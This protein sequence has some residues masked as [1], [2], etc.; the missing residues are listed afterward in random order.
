M[1]SYG[2][3]STLVPKILVVAVT[4]ALVYLVLQVGVKKLVLE[5]LVRRNIVTASTLEQMYRPLEAI[6]VAL[7][8]LVVAY[9]VTYDPVV[10]ASLVVLVACLG[11]AL[12][13]LLSNIV[14][15]YIVV[16]GHKLRAGD[17]IEFEGT[18]GRVVR[19]TPFHVV[20]RTRNGYTLVVP[21][22]LLLERS[23]ERAGSGSVRVRLRVSIALPRGVENVVARLNEVEGRIRSTLHARRLIQKGQDVS[24]LIEHIE[25]GKAVLDIIV[26]VPSP[27][28]RLQAVNAIVR[29]VAEAL[30]DY[31]PQIEVTDR[32]LLQ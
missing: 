19:V 3:A 4:V 17:V 23:F 16:L 8:A 10:A 15:F 11:A 32:A 31:N 26:P 14:A 2:L 9:L 30:I 18:R 7:S 6:L 13:P 22:K 20:L 1:V 25:S 24:I 12:W 27:E 29:H 5:N 28:P 21:N